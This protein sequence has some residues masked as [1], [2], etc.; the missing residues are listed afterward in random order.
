MNIL[1]IG[2]IMGE[3]G[4]RVLLKHLSKAIKDYHIDL[5][6]GNGENAAGG[7]GITPDIAEELFDLGL[8]AITLG[9]HAWDKREA[10]EYLQKESRVIRPANYPDGV[11]GKGTCVMAR[12][13]DCRRACRQNRK[14]PA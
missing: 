13:R 14:E 1:F 9:N 3:P 7:F 6:V 5:V 2:D 11:P 12:R 10:M 8:S 4:R